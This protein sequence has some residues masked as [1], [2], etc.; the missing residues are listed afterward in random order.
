MKFI[1]KH[2]LLFLMVLLCLPVIGLIS[3]KYY[4]D[5]QRNDRQFPELI[6]IAKFL[7]SYPQQAP[8]LSI[9]NLAEALDPKL[10]M[11][12]LIINSKAE[13]L[14]QNQQ[15]DASL[16]LNID[17]NKLSTIGTH[18][19]ALKEIQI[20]DKILNSNLGSRHGPMFFNE[21]I[22][23][24]QFPDRYLMIQQKHWAKPPPRPPGSGIMLLPP[25][26]GPPP[27]IFSL[28]IIFL[29]VCVALGLS[30]LIV[31]RKYSQ[32]SEQAKDVMQSLKAGNLKSRFQNT[33]K[34][35]IGEIMT[36]FNIM[37]DEIEH[38]VQHL[39]DIQNTRTKVLQE[40]AHDLRTPIASMKSMLEGLYDKDSKLSTEQKQE[41]LKLSLYEIDYFTKLID[42]LLWLARINETQYQNFAKLCDIKQIL[43][44]EISIAK[45]KNKNLNF[46]FHSNSDKIEMTADPHQMT[47][48]FRNILENAAQFAKS[49]VMIELKVD[50]NKFHLLICDDGSGF[51][52]DSLQNFGDKKLSRS[53]AQNSGLRASVGLGNLIIKSV[54]DMHRLQLKVSNSISTN[55]AQ[56]EISN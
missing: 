30:F 15:D 28:L 49:K 31:Y 52:Q 6:D 46:V 50:Q 8:E 56:I 37:A 11:Q 3:Q 55:G 43:E 26:W 27:F 20:A 38:L 16:K 19:H 32:L 2:Y 35:E 5:Y 13:I 24:L 39:T 45:T 9:Q 18:K 22:S 42:D 23:K 36:S 41:F 7:N 53:L 51:D 47:R 33:R 25:S 14:F 48:M 12:I 10:P 54:A 21:Y 44:D 34:D 17:T 1:A 40:L 4:M 29:S